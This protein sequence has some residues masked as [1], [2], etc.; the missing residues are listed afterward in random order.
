MRYL[1]PLLFWGVCY[2]FFTPLFSQGLDIDNLAEEYYS[3]SRTQ[4]V[5]TALLPIPFGNRIFYDGV[6]NNY[7]DN[8]IW[9]TEGVAWIVT[10][11]AGLTL[12]GDEDF[13]RVPLGIFG[14]LT[15]YIAGWVVVG[16][17]TSLTALA[18]QG[19]DKNQT[20]QIGG[21][22]GSIAG[23]VAGG[24]IGVDLSQNIN[25]NTAQKTMYYAFAVAYL[26]NILDAAV[27]EIDQKLV[28]DSSLHISPIYDLAQ[29][30][31]GL[32]VALSF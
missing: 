1:L 4:T 5:L 32:G 15:G 30:G 18:I 23:A 14:G 25:I 13:K 9:V 10:G 19:H 20:F 8:L 21:A 31:M 7:V 27:F 29:N 2:T 28:T 22:I 16:S 17:L 11:M 3:P 12:L 24:I 6:D 26:L